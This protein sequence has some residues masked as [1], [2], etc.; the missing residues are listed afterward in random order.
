[1]EADLPRFW[2]RLISRRKRAKDALCDS[3]GVMATACIQE[4]DRCN[5]GSPLRGRGIDQPEAGDGQAGRD[6][7]AE[8]PAVLRM[9]GN[10]SGGK[11]L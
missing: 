10:A 9:L 8:R 3:T 4:E 2:G 11:G 7:V 6:G 5:T 1:M